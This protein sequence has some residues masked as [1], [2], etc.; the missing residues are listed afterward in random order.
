MSSLTSVAERQ[1]VQSLTSADPPPVVECQVKWYS[2]DKGFGFVVVGDGGEDAFLHAAVLEKSRMA[3]IP[4]AGAKILCKVGY[5]S[6]RRRVTQVLKIDNST[7][8]APPR[9]RTAAAPP[10]DIPAVVGEPEVAT[11]RW[12]NRIKGF[13]FVSRGEETE[14][15]FVHMVVLHSCGMRELRLGQS[16]LVWF[17][18]TEKGLMAS[19]IQFT[20]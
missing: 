9:Q 12:F 11:V 3:H 20:S 2:P 14:D 4:G 15:I 19:K 5:E 10:Q 17:D 18:R 16:V 13:G 7:A 1:S 6:G 8:T